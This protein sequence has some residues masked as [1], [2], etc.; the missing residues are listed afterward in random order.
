MQDAE[1]IGKKM[2]KRTGMGAYRR[3]DKFDVSDAGG[4]TVGVLW[5]L[6]D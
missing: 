6:Q 5:I 1:I 2:E 4:S 3:A